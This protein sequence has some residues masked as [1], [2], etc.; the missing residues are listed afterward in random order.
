MKQLRNA[1]LALAFTCLPAGL[2]AQGLSVT[3]TCPATANS[4]ATYTCT[5][6]VRAT[7][8]AGINIDNIV[9]T[10]TYPYPGTPVAV[11]CLVGGIPVDTLP[12]GSTC[13]G[14]VN[15]VAPACGGSNVTATDRID[16][17]G[18]D[19][20]SGDPVAAFSAQTITV[21]ACTPTPTITPTRTRTPTTGPGTDTPTPLPSP[22]TIGLLVQ[23]GPPFPGL[24]TVVAPGATVTLDFSV[25]NK[26]SAGE[27]HS[28]TVSDTAPDPGGPVTFWPCY[29]GGVAVDMLAPNGQSGDT[30]TGTVTFTAEACQSVAH[31]M[32]DKVF[33]IGSDT[34]TFGGS[35][36]SAEWF[37]VV[38]ACTPTPTF[39]PSV[40]PGGPTFTPTRTPGGPTD[41]PT[42]TPTVTPTRTF[43][44]T[45]GG[46]TQT[47]TPTV[48]PGGPTSTPL[49]TNPPT[50][51]NPPTPTPTP[52]G[53]TPTPSRTPGG[54]T[55]TPTSGPA[56]CGT[57]L[58]GNARNAA[59]SLLTINGV[60]WFTLSGN[61]NA[62]CCSPPYQVGPAPPITFALTN[63]AIAAGSQLL[64]N[65]CIS[66][67]GTCY[68]ESIIDRNGGVALRR[69]VRIQG[70]IINIGEL[71]PCTPG[72]GGAPPGPPAGAPG[73]PG[74]AGPPG[75]NGPPGVCAGCTI[76]Y[77]TSG[78]Y[79][80]TA[81]DSI[82]FADATAGVV[83]INL[84]ANPDEC[85]ILDI[86]KVAGTHAVVING[87]GNTIDG[88][89]T[90]TI[91]TLY[92]SIELAFQATFKWGVI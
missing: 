17:A 62:S 6:S 57:L 22:P 80:V 77:L 18:N 68:L 26:D 21:I 51:T 36:G 10:E 60:V 79:N 63:G 5:F 74:P 89:G 75:A 70:S 81:N 78:T 9:V 19:R 49:P 25:T 30:C 43:T 61:G 24:H 66:P 65:D 37:I 83:T 45:A 7:G 4:G 23:K 3:K 54:N 1:L 42:N 41:T 64:G 11:Q 76:V 58:Y 55:P 84:P 59:G 2:F 53:P 12:R 92:E 91:N 39:T 29:Q 28:L 90:R 44:I 20:D 82:I 71:P 31:N 38:L 56:V 8:P 47:R 32:Y 48:T 72:G 52:T 69:N 50:R 35:S 16:A 86:K 14:S 73:P 33:A 40:T 87:N 34:F 85:R 88:A 67:P 46:P 13:T 27:V 15:E